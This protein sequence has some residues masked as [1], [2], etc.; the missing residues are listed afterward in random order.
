MGKA[1]EKFWSLGEKPPLVVGTSWWMSGVL[2]FSKS[3]LFGKLP[4]SLK[5]AKKRILILKCYTTEG[6]ARTDVCLGLGVC[7]G[8]GGLGCP[9]RAGFGKHGRGTSQMLPKVSKMAWTAGV[10]HR[11][12]CSG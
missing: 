4:L 2:C 5:N 3:C 7:A 12:C 11:Q 9:F 6:Q 10:P 8:P 1:R